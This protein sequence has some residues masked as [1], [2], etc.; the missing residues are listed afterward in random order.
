ML[1]AFDA[2]TV[3]LDDQIGDATRTRT[4]RLT[5]W[6]SGFGASNLADQFD[7]WCRKSATAGESKAIMRD[8]PR[9]YA[10]QLTLPLFT[11]ADGAQGRVHLQTL[12]HALKAQ[13]GFYCQGLNFVAAHVLCAHAEA[14]GSAHT[15]SGR[16]LA[17][18]FGTLA[19]ATRCFSEMWSPGLAL[20]NAAVAAIDAL[21]RDAAPSV[22]AHLTAHASQSLGEVARAWLLTLF[23][24]P[25]IPL[26]WRLWLWD[27]MA[28]AC[29]GEAAP[30]AASGAA[31]G[32]AAGVA[33]SCAVCAV[34]AA[35]TAQQ[36]RLLA[37]ADA[38]ALQE[39]LVGAWGALCVETS[40]GALAR[41]AA[42]VSAHLPPRWWPAQA[43]GE[44][45]GA[46]TDPI[47]S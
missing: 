18:A 28:A 13:A 41:E 24:H 14:R 12:L 42:R 2:V 16:A 17:N 6:A 26:A 5:A 3:A 29:A 11:E 33:L 20:A 9:T 30:G 47:H 34:V 4:L 35:A 38:M 25:T 27:L 23:A 31:D 46:G 40:A 36:D 45:L 19:A 8:V 44:S 43:P 22:S 32:A 39:A 10:D 15:V 37:T 21:L 7:E 1:A